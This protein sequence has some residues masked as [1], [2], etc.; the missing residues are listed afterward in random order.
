MDVLDWLR[1]AMLP[2]ILPGVVSVVVSAIVTLL[3]GPAMARRQE[4]AR[5][6][7]A[8]RRKIARHLLRLMHLL[9]R[10][11]SCRSI[12]K[13]GGRVP[14]DE[15]LN[16]TDVDRIL[17]QIVQR[18]QDPDLDP[19]AARWLQSEL[20]KLIGPDMIHLLLSC[21]TEQALESEWEPQRQAFVRYV[22]RGHGT[23]SYRW[24]R[25]F[26]DD[27]GRRDLQQMQ[28]TLSE[29]R[30]ICSKWLSKTG[31]VVP[32]EA[33]ASSLKPAQLIRRR[34]SGSGE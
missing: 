13:S 8:V 9:E 5:R 26:A 16:R 6:D 2:A 27:E 34:E 25:L 15:F 11:L 31:M 1:S 14:P 10:E 7:L 12:Q 19:K 18:L 4:A 17:W 33:S 3:L 29:I 24:D 28:E 20:A 30:R 22:S 21:P 23:Q 32:M